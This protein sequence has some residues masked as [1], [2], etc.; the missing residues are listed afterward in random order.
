ML[1]GQDFLCRQ[2]R[3]VTPVAASFLLGFICNLGSAVSLGPPAAGA[4]ARASIPGIAR[5]DPGAASHAFPRAS[6]VC[7]C[8]WSHMQAAGLR[9]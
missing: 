3:G 1:T 7:F 8:E 5:V 4:E 9:G 2:W 6:P